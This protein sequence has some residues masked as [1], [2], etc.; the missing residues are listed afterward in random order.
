MLAIG[1]EI[2]YRIADILRDHFWSFFRAEKGWYRPVVFETVRKLLACRTPAL[3][4]HLYSCQDCGRVEVVPHSCKS[5]FCSTCGKHATDRWSQAALGDLLDV[6]YHHV[7]LAAPWQLRSLIAM[8]R[9]V[10]LSILA[11]AAAACM[12]QWSR[13][14]HAMIMG[15]VS[16][17]HTFGSDLKWHPH[18]HL[19]V[20]QGG[21]SLDGTRWVR[22]YGE[23][24]LRDHRGLKAMWR[25]HV[26]TLLRRAKK[27]GRLRFP[28]GCAFLREY[29]RFNAFLNTLYQL[30]WYAHIGA[31]LDDPGPSLRY[32]GRY[33]KRAVLAEYRITHYDGKTVRY[34]YRD[35]AS[36]GKTAFKTLPVRAFLRRLLRHIPDK[37]FKMVRYAGLFAPRWKKG[38]LEKARA[39]LAHEAAAST[40]PTPTPTPSAGALEA[41]L[42]RIVPCPECHTP[43]TLTAVVFGPHPLVE[44][45][46]HMAGR[47]IRPPP[48][49]PAMA[50]AA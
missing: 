44:R 6:P 31:A 7:V 38:Y 14:Q 27:E 11:R 29:P 32:I 12:N 18:V 17:I 47:P 43:M 21:L 45:H 16:V 35:Y 41:P 1:T 19:L 37:H 4:C 36:G 20:T 40:S 15:I 50:R 24:W 10:G 2:R 34:A 13:E 30:N 46:F 33:T 22:P 26:V 48:H 3:G 28:E 9:A 8:N 23:G 25:Y 39:V 49:R 5:R 42:P